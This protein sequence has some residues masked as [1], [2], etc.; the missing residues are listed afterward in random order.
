MKNLYKYTAAAVA[1]AMVMIFA[2]CGSGNGEKIT[3]EDSAEAT[4]NESP[5]P[6]NDENPAPEAEATNGVRY[7]TVLREAA[8]NSYSGVGSFEA[9]DEVTV[10]PKV[11]GT[12]TAMPKDEG[13]MVGEKTV[14]AQLDKED[15]ELGL[16]NAQAQLKIAEVSL[17]NAQN[18]YNRKKKLVDQGAIPVGQ[19][20]SFV[21]QLELAKAQVDAARIAI[22]VNEKALRDTTTYAGVR[23]IVSHRMMAAGEFI[24]AGDPLLT[25]SILDPIKLKFSVP[26]NLAAGLVKGNSVKATISAYP[27]K[28]FEG[29][30]ALI[31]PNVDARTRTIPVEA[32]FRNSDNLIK[33]GFFAE[34][35][36]SLLAGQDMYIVPTDALI[37]NESGTFVKVI[38]NMEPTMVQVFV[39]ENM[40]NNS[41]VLGQLEDGQKVELR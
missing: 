20:D 8:A 1:L 14:V 17:K 3:L 18:E 10:A 4:S 12:I 15:F 5:A 13:D 35:T 21:T 23:G 11:G 34:C 29:K 24:G 19:F 36:V 27:G 9:E 33:P 39:V 28:E 38:L 26:Q 2:A 25:V 37:K 22:E 40:G 16:K 31:S 30:I 32:E 6:A 41:K 7:G